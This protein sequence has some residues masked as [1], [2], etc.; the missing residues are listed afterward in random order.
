ML[1]ELP[2]QHIAQMR[3]VVCPFGDVVLC[4]RLTAWPVVGSEP[5]MPALQPSSDTCDPRGLHEEYYTR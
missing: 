1:P 5:R 4:A 3:C 2:M